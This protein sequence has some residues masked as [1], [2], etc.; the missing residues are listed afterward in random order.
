MNETLVTIRD[1]QVQFD[2]RVGRVQAVDHV[3][4]DIQHGE[5]LGLVG[6]SGCGKST[7]GFS[8]LRLI[9]PPGL[10]VGGSIVFDGENL[11][12]QSEAEMNRLRGK[13]IAM[14][15]QDPMT[16]L[17]PLQRIDDHFVETIRTH[18]P[19]VTRE[20]A[21]QRARDMFEHLGIAP[22][23]L[24]DYPHQLS[25]GM[26]QRVMIGLALVLNSDLVIADE[27]TTSLDVIVEA[28]ILDL[29]RD[30][31]REY[32]VTMILITHNMGI[33]AEMADRI[34]VMYA[35]RIAEIA[36]AQALFDSPKHPYTQGLLRSI[37][38]ILLK[39]QELAS[40][41]G[42][43]PHLIDQQP[44]CRFAPRCPQVMPAC[45]EVNPPLV[46]VGP[47]RQAACLLYQ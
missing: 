27:P 20:Q 1:L 13:R 3:D 17:N 36:P 6:E 46:N 32:G 18:E 23:R 8:I 34:A 38:N 11:L 9:R 29:M 31:Q 12:A 45:R 40:L 24:I 25:G 44:W 28:Q 42:S 43:P 4:L 5:V 26:R 22:E 37:P 47:R 33:V 35:G 2:T 7:L 14:I 15:F 16:S 39:D 41:P 10:I 21:V 30:L 19:Q